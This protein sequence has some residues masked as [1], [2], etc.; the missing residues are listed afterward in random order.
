MYIRLS[1]QI[2]RCHGLFEFIQYSIFIKAFLVTK[3]KSEIPPSSWLS[4]LLPYICYKESRNL[5]HYRCI[6]KA[7]LDEFCDGRDKSM[8]DK[9]SRIYFT[10]I[11]CKVH[12]Q[13]QFAHWP[14]N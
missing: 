9:H 10:L 13:I 2:Q 14:E 3:E 7:R 4:L 11:L 8:M 5:E 12:V 1:G 6:I